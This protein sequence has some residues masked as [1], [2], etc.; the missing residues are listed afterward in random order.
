LQFSRPRTIV[1]ASKHCSVVKVPAIPAIKK[2]ASLAA[3]VRVIPGVSPGTE[4]YYTTTRPAL[5]RAFHP[6][7]EDF[8]GRL[9]RVDAS[10]IV[11]TLPCVAVPAAYNALFRGAVN[12]TSTS[13]PGQGILVIVLRKFPY[14]V[15][16]ME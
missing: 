5:S 13:S 1:I 16:K 3:P 14:Y 10:C 2:A 6:F 15:P 12:N 11:V 7:L 8:R 4:I 9:S